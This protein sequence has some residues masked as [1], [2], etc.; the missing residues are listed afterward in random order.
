MDP[1][2]DQ[3]REFIARQ[4]KTFEMKSKAIKTADL[5]RRVGGLAV[6]APEERDFVSSAESKVLYE[7]MRA[8]GLN[9]ETD[10]ICWTYFRRLPQEDQEVLPKM[11]DDITLEV[12]QMHL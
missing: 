11:Q 7:A 3:A 12:L 10:P 1:V 5:T 9:I 4:E 8:V 2:V 6:V